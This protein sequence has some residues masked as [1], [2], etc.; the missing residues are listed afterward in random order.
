MVLALGLRLFFIDTF[1]SEE[2]YRSDITRAVDR[3]MAVIERDAEQLKRQLV[4][5]PSLSFASFTYPSRYP[6]YIFQQGELLYW[7]DYR[8]VPAYNYLRGAYTYAYR[9][10]PSGSYVVRRDSTV[11][12]SLEIFFLLPI[13]RDTKI[14]NQ[15]VSSGYN[16]ALFPEGAG[17]TMAA[18][19]IDID[20]RAKLIDYQGNPLFAVT[21]QEP[22]GGFR[23]HRS[24]KLFQTLIS[25][26]VAL[27]IV[28]VLFNIGRVIRWDL[29]QRNTD[30]AIVSFTLSLVGVR[31]LMLAFNFPY[32]ILPLRLFDYRYFASSTVNPSLGDL[33]LN[34]LCGLFIL[35][36]LFNNY[37]ATRAYRKLF[38]APALVKTGVAV[39]LFLAGFYALY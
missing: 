22:V 34:C 28:L 3:A 10:L 39:A 31:A 17:A 2:E 25:L 37:Y 21:L 11:S 38:S 29:R 4:D 16:P 30:R 23:A 26:L 15:Y 7:S 18:S 1:R 33:L 32:T 14:D 19:V 35:I 27:S 24:A 5:A 12:P 6:Y 13:R 36:F 20:N 8:Q 9:T